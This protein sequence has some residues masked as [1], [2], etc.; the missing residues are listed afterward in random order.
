[1]MFH[2]FHNSRID[3]TSDGQALLIHNLASLISNQFV[4]EAPLTPTIAAR[5]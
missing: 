2:I 5:L 1:M 3:T 4:C